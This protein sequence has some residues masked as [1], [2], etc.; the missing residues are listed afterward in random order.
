MNKPKILFLSDVDITTSG[1]AQE[2]MKILM[3]ELDQFFE[4]YLIGPRG[5]KINDRHI[6]LSRYENF[7]VRGKN[8][9][10]LKNLAFELSNE[11]KKVNADIIHI[12]MP[13]TLVLLN[14]LFK[15]KRIKKNSAGI[16]Y[17]DRGVY[18]KYGKITTLSINA[19]INK[20]N[21]IV[22]T[23]SVNKNNYKD[24]YNAY[25]KYS[26][27]FEVVYNTAGK[28]F[29]DYDSNKRLSI[30]S[31]YHLNDNQFVIGF[32][33]RFTDQKNW[34]LTKEIIESYADESYIKFLVVLGSNGNQ[35]DY[36]NSAEYIESLKKIVG[37]NRIISFID[38][39]NKEMS[40][41]YYA[42]DCF[43]LTS[44]WESFGRTAVEAMA[45]KNAVVGTDVDGLSEVIG[46]KKY[47]FNTAD[48]AINIVNEM[49]RNKENLV[50]AKDYF[51]KRYHTFFGYKTN[52]EMYKKLYNQVLNEKFIR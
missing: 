4:F 35:E 34:P 11:I 12:Q 25:N 20:A 49:I 31:K 37:E 21:K 36:R 2:S 44:K 9:L 48:E 22:T 16:V 29:D 41:L 24:L 43:I 32:C 19:I 14:I 47:I 39:T 28:I 52:I 17:T 27:K 51:Y 50:M 1:G 30:R 42:M 40:D 38:I 46:N 5:K 6:V 8:F 26:S 7:I 18:G 15:L 23:T 13:S 3:E 10:E 33:G 45:R